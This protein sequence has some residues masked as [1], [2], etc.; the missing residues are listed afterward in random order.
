M[1]IPDCVAGLAH[2]GRHRSSILYHGGP[3]DLLK[4]ARQALT[5]PS[6]SGTLRANS[7]LCRHRGGGVSTA[8][9]ESDLRE[10][11]RSASS[12]AAP[13]LSLNLRRC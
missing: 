1:S 4:A 13:A 9:E 5:G 12:S 8:D 6:A 10:T 2:K 7:L 3:A 11:W